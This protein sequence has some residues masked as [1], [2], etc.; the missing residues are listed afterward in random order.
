M[1]VARTRE[2]VKGEYRESGNTDT[3]EDTTTHKGRSF[4]KRLQARCVA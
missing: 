4:I 2:K 1:G 3:G